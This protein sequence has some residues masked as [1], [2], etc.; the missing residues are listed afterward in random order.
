LT[1]KS[2]P[3]GKIAQIR[4]PCLRLLKRS[5]R[6]IKSWNSCFSQRW[7]SPKRYIGFSRWSKI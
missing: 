6:C 1:I 7:N 4:S 3:I 2:C 5:N